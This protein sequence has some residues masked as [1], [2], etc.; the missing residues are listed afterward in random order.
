MVHLAVSRYNNASW[1]ELKQ[2]ME[3]NQIQGCIYNTPVRITENVGLKT[4]VIVLEMNNDKNQI[5]AIG[6]IENYLRMDQYYKIH[7]DNNYNRYSYRGERRILRKDFNDLEEAVIRIFDQMVFKG[8]GHMKRG[9]GIQ[10]INKKKISK[11]MIGNKTLDQFMED[12]FL[13]RT[14]E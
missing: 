5:Y 4:T 11:I 12:M 7:A 14:S 3:A 13:F 6:Q 8:S 1:R 9:Q 10:V 2:F